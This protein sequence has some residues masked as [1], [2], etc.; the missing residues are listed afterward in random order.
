MEQGLR[1]NKAHL[2]DRRDN[3][4]GLMIAKSGSKQVD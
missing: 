3:L 4:L 1:Q 2:Y